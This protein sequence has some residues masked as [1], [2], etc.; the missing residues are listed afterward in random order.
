[1]TKGE[2]RNKA[3]IRLAILI[4]ADLGIKILRHAEHPLVLL[5]M[6]HL[7]RHACGI[8]AF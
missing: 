7:C 5:L 1:M 8:S 4:L 2:V 6:Q 3:R